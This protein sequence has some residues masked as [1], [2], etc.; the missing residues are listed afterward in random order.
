MLRRSTGRTNTG[1]TAFTL[2]ELLIVVA[3][4]A[5]L[6]AIAVPNFLEAQTR[7]KV[8]RSRADLRS[9]L[10]A[11]ETYHIDSNDYPRA[12]E[13]SLTTG[14]YYQY[15]ANIHERV[16]SL[17]TTPIAY[18]NSIP[19]DPFDPQPEIR[20]PLHRFKGRYMY[21]NLQYVLKASPGNTQY[22]RATEMAG[23]YVTASNGPDRIKYNEP[24]GKNPVTRGQWI[25]YDASNGTI[26][27]GNVIRS[28]K[29][30]EQFGVADWVM[31]AY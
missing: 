9:V 15:N 10:T 8:S 21:L 26:S 25:D 7:A 22:V 13:A 11:L 28:Q 27:R 24:P 30:S 6:A 2:I 20:E 14:D 1:T 31:N 4:I 5:I 16:P 18:L 12:A 23:A 17:L 29:N 19:T 3:I